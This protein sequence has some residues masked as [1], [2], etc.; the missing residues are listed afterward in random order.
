MNLDEIIDLWRKDS[1]IDQTEIGDE[2]ERT[3]SLHAK[4]I[5]LLQKEKLKK[6]GYEYEYKRTKLIAWEEYQQGPPK[7]SK[8]NPPAIGRVL[9]Q[10]VPMYIEAD[11]QLQSLSAEIDLC[12]SK[13]EV[14]SGI[15]NIIQYRNNSVSGVLEW[16]KWS[17]GG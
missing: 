17:G 15:V 10:D 3:Y 2:L 12:E 13:I 1:K 4:Y 9:K 8:R 5:D 14:L 16:I 6:K 7:E 11:E